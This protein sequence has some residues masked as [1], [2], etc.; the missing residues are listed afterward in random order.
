MQRNYLLLIMVMILFTGFW[1]AENNLYSPLPSKIADLEDEQVTFNERLITAQI[2]SEEMDMVY[3][4]FENNM[5]SKDNKSLKEN[6][7]IEFLNDLTDILN[8]L[9]ITVLHI[10]PGLK[11]DRESYTFI[12]YEL[13]IECTYEEFGKFITELESNDRL[14]SI[15]EFLLNNGLERMSLSKSRD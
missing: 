12:P 11:T 6:A 13:E 9:E 3:S 4:I 7:S 5:F 8:K 2:L 1:Y 14:I 15:D 10:K